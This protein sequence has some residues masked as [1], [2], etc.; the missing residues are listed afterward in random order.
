MNCYMQYNKLSYYSCCIKF[1]YNGRKLV[2][3]S[4]C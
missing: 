1:D 3:E 4:G 2:G